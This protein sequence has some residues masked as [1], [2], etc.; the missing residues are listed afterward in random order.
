VTIPTIDHGVVKA[1]F[2]DCIAAACAEVDMPP[3]RLRMDV[4][5]TGCI[6]H[7]AV[8]RMMIGRAMHPDEMG[9]PCFDIVEPRVETAWRSKTATMI[10]KHA[11]TISRLE[12]RRDAFDPDRTGARATKRMWDIHPVAASVLMQYAR[13]P[14]FD[15][16]HRLDGMVGR[17][18][19]LGSAPGIE[20][21]VIGYGDG[22]IR[23]TE[24]R[25]SDDATLRLDDDDLK[26]K[27]TGT[28]PD[29]LVS[30]MKGA[31]P[32]A[33]ASMLGADPRTRRCKVKR[34]E[35]MG[36]GTLELTF[37]DVLVPWD[38]RAKGGEPW[39]KRRLRD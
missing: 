8:D 25:F 30:A 32:E 1:F 19:R 18:I 27:L 11:A 34:V 21:A 2:D 3:E 36:D 39:R 14:A 20:S 15:G 7:D 29:I 16:S 37:P 31:R 13:L 10:R 38:R 26:L 12:A 22:V 17:V 28:Y 5:L 35:R 24:V 4:R 9:R 23:L 6:T 33:I